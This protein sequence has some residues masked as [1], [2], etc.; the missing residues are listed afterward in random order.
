MKE[1]LF[2]KNLKHKH[3]IGFEDAFVT[4]KDEKNIEMNII[5]ELAEGGNL[6]K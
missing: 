6:F 1:V 5:T 4:T 3:I 2:L